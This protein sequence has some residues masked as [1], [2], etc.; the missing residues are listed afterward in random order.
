MGWQKNILSKLQ[1]V[2]CLEVCWLFEMKYPS[3]NRLI[4]NSFLFSLKNCK[5]SL[6]I[7]PWHEEFTELSFSFG[8]CTNFYQ[9]I[10]LAMWRG[11]Q[12]KCTSTDLSWKGN[13]Y[14]FTEKNVIFL[15]RKRDITWSSV[16]QSANFLLC[17]A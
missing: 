14:N 16:L 9:H 11:R 10:H 6:L 13:V 7:L 15:R 2:R 5:F 4:V 1:P 12:I 17:L 3:S 8:R